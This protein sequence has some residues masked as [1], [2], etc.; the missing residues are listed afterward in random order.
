VA[1]ARRQSKSATT[2]AASARA[3]VSTASGAS[4][5]RGTPVADTEA[6]A[7]QS[8]DSSV[9]HVPSCNGD[10]ELS[11]TARVLLIGVC[12]DRR[13][14]V[15]RVWCG[16]V[17]GVRCAADA[18]GDSPRHAAVVGTENS[19]RAHRY[20]VGSTSPL[21]NASQRGARN[22]SRG[23]GRGVKSGAGS[24]RVHVLGSASTA[25]VTSGGTSTPPAA[26]SATPAS[27]GGVSAA[28]GAAPSAGT[29]VGGAGTAAAHAHGGLP[30]HGGGGGGGLAL[31]SRGKRPAAKQWKL[32]GQ[33]RSHSVRVACRVD[34]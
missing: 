14:F 22:H 24:G 26:S 8:L 7:P 17:H 1:P 29:S 28:A 12:D 3:G 19:A 20:S 25:A 16:V 21:R 15:D 9:L 18:E 13:N 33:L 23:G 32:K 34:E 30:S 27:G 11:G 5:S 10:S 6:A 2:A 31:S 4:P